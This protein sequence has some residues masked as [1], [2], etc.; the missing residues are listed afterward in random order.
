MDKLIGYLIFLALLG[1]WS[2]SLYYLVKNDK[3]ENYNFKLWGPFLMWHTEK[4]KTLIDKAAKK[5]RL[6]ELYGNFAIILCLV[7]MVLMFFL[8]LWEATIVSSIPKDSA[9]SPKMMIGIPGINPLIPVWYGIVGL[10]VAMVVHELLHGILTRTGGLTL[11][12]LGLLFFIIPLGA[13]AEPDSDELIATTK[14]KRS[15]VFAVGP[16]TNIIVALLFVGMFSWSCMGSVEA[17]ED[18]VLVRGVSP[19]SAV[20]ETGLTDAWTEITCI[21]GIS[22]ISN[23]DFENFPGPPPNTNITIRTLYEGEQVNHVVPSG[24]LVVSVTDDMGLTAAKHGIEPGM[25]IAS[26]NGTTIRNDAGFSQALNLIN[27]GQ[28]VSVQV[29]NFNG[30]DIYYS[31]NSDITFLN[32]SKMDKWTYYEAHWPSSNKEEYKGKAFM[33]VSTAYLGLAIRDINGLPDSLSRPL[34]GSESLTDVGFN[35]ML[36]IAQPF[37]G[38][39]PLRSPITDL[40]EPTGLWGFLPDSA[41]WIIANCFYWIFWLNIMVGLT[42]ALPAVP[43]DGGY[44]FKDVVTHLVEKIHKKGDKKAIEKGVEKITLVI[45]LTVLFLIIWQLVGPRVL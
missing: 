42:N 39:S 2:V 3:L 23:E 7:V 25:M 44:I 19:Y 10:V 26:L 43:M 14:K 21:E 24:V 17:K 15:R 40:Y 12:S 27:A 36:F 34:A 16:A 31:I 1:A 33:G 37:R 22:I 29:L 35:A 5:K 32:F 30:S 38:T 13:F 11:K 9:P 6:W 4:G 28:N 8:L 41:F 45:A 20:Y 18:G